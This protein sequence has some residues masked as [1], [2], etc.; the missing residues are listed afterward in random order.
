MDWNRVVGSD[1]A[2]RFCCLGRV[3]VGRAEG[4]TPAADRDHGY[5]DGPEV[6]HAMEQ[7][8]IAGGNLRTY[9]M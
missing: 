9:S 5:I 6:V 1:P 8:G 2:D 4:G 3:E 7:A